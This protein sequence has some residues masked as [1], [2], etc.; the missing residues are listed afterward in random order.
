VSHIRIV[1]DDG[2]PYLVQ[3]VFYDGC[4]DCGCVHKMKLKKISA[5]VYELTATRDERRT[6]QTRR[7]HLYDFVDLAGIRALA[8]AEV[9][10]GLKGRRRKRRTKR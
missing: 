1:A 3:S 9:L 6:A 8:N 7:R 10:A 4:C 5:R 2:I